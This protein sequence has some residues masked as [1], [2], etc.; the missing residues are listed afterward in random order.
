MQNVYKL[1]STVVKLIEFEVDN[2]SITTISLCETQFVRVS[3]KDIG[4][5]SIHGISV[6]YREHRQ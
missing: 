1:I 4:D 2:G 5:T 3:F 6:I